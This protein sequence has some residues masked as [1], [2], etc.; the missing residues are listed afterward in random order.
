MEV[1][2]LDLPIQDVERLRKV[3]NK[4]VP[5]KNVWAYGS[6][7]KGTASKHSDL[8]M[9]VFGASEAQLYETRDALE[10]SNVPVEVQ[11]FR[12]ED[13]PT[14]FHDNIQQAYCVVQREADWCEMTLADISLDISYGYTASATDED[15]GCK[16]LRITDIVPYFPNWESIPYCKI[17]DTDKNKYRLLLGDIVIARTGA[18]SGY[19]YRVDRNEEA[20]FASYLIRFRINE[21]KAL[22]LFVKYYF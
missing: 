4:H 13:L 22:S 21:Q 12:W 17:S 20:V 7:V 11:L 6:R 19:N 1:T 10:E 14:H 18:T 8:D 3:L 9:V 2:Q 15:T 5:F 16:F